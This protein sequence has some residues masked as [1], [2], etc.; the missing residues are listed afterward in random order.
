MA[1]ELLA[2]KYLWFHIHVSTRC[3]VKRRQSLDSISH[4]SMHVQLFIR[5]WSMISV[6][7]DICSFCMAFRSP[8]CK[9]HCS[10]PH[11]KRCL[12]SRSLAV[13]M[14]SNILWCMYHLYATS[15]WG[16]LSVEMAIALPRHMV[17]LY[18]YIIV[19]LLIRVVSFRS[20]YLVVSLSSDSLSACIVI[21]V[22]TSYVA[23]QWDISWVSKY[24]L[25][26]SSYLSFLL[27]IVSREKAIVSH[28]LLC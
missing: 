9:Y 26:V 27:S 11:D 7:W 18:A 17:C 13:S 8:G 19:L 25:G 5:V 15:D 24:P 2:C 3:P 1:C 22:L 23:F 20:R 14:V 21:T 16:H 6:R 12:R 28:L 4:T 10:P